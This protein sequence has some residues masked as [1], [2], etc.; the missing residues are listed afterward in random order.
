MGWR[1]RA[2]DRWRRHSDNASAKW[3]APPSHVKCWFDK[4]RQQFRYC[5][6][7]VTIV[8]GDVLDRT[9]TSFICWQTCDWLQGRESQQLRRQRLAVHD[10]CNNRPQAVSHGKFHDKHDFLCVIFSI[11]M[12][13]KMSHHQF[14]VNETRWCHRILNAWAPIELIVRLVYF[15]HTYE[16]LNCW[17]LGMGV[18]M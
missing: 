6:I 16:K 15:S 4:S 3:C 10:N 14:Y 12:S 18:R 17:P 8:N 7:L 5:A 1:R 2:D 11:A 13:Q 9:W